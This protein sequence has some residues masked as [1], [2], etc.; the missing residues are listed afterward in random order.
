L[1]RITR[2]LALGTISDQPSAADLK[3]LMRLQQ[4]GQELKSKAALVS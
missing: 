3:F 1:R 4:F 2:I